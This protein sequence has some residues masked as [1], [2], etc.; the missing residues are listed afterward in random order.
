M[1]HAENVQQDTIS[2]WIETARKFQT[3]A[4]TSILIKLGASGAIKGTH[5]TGIINAWLVLKQHRIQGA[6]NS[7]TAN[8]WN[9]LSDSILEKMGSANWFHP[10]ARTS[11]LLTKNAINAIQD[12]HWMLGPTVYKPHQLWLTRG[13][14]NS[15]MENAQNA[16][17]DST[18]IRIVS[19][20][21][22]LRHAATSMRSHRSAMA[23]TQ[24]ILWATPNNA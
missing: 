24:D 14:L 12:I 4:Q 15:K 23:A 20:K 8:V 3:L 10:L 19:A 9:V 6:T 7:K 21:W 17:S 2:T 13:A 5:S 1:G 18:L 11:I 16:H 22:L